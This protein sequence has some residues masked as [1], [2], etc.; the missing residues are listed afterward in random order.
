METFGPADLAERFAPLKQARGALLAVSGG[1]DSVALMLLAHAWVQASGG[2]DKAAARLAVATVDHGLRPQS[3]Q[4]A[5]AVAGWAAALGLP[6]HILDWQGEKP[7]A[8]IQERAREAR[9]ALLFA[10]ARAI[11]ADYVLTAH[12]AD[13]QAETILFRLLRG[14]GLS[15]LAGMSDAAERGNLVHLR[16]LLDCPKDALIGVCEAHGHPYFRDASNENL[17]YARARLRKLAPILAA[18]GLDRDAL[19]RLGRRA[20]RADAALDA[21]MRKLRSALP[22]TRVGGTFC[23]PMRAFKDE[24]AEILARLIEAEIRF[25]G[26]DRPLRLDRLETL[27][28][29]LQAALRQD[30]AWCGSLAGKAL[31]LDRGGVLT[32]RSENPRRR[33]RQATKSGDHASLQEAATRVAPLLCSDR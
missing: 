23:A 7:K 14:S 17:A 27:T 31:V 5:E 10:H 12:H 33:G 6:H 30:A 8:A 15:G 16:P 22:A 4:E 13:D 1:P 24:P 26:T 28:A 29:S 32:V 21:C 19:L 18:E 20:E 3:R 11:G 2:Q 25:L 9:Y